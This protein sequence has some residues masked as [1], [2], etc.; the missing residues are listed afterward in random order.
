MG[1]DEI[2]FVTLDDV[3]NIFT[4]ELDRMESY[5]R[6]NG[7]PGRYQEI[8]ESMYEIRDKLIDLA[9]GNLKVYLQKNPDV[10]KEIR[11]KR[12]AETKKDEKIDWK[13]KVKENREK[14]FN[15]DSTSK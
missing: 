9:K 4:I 14:Y 5:L 15:S 1:I 10:K 2:G 7:V 13:D 12:M 3:R 8:L 11:D 6:H